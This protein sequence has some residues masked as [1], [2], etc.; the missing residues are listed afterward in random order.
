[1]TPDDLLRLIDNQ[2]DNFIERKSQ[3]VTAGE[4]RQ[5]ATAFANAV[6][7]GRGAVLFIGI[8]DR[9][10]A[11]VGVSNTDA[12]QKR[13]R[14]ALREDCFPPIDYTSEVLAVRDRTVVAVVIPASAS[15][16]HFVGPAFAR[17]GSESVTASLEQYK[18]L[19]LSLALAISTMTR[20]LG[21]VGT[22]RA[23]TRLP[24]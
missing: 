14:T 2:E 23:W 12:L 16:P 10:G 15:R 5:T 8:A 19:I 4:L 20:S 1:M 6:P 18:E 13:V 7:E 11:V 17:V 21:S 24:A 3:G 22:A 9:S